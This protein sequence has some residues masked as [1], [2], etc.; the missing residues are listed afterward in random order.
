MTAVTL[1]RVVKAYPGGVRA[2]DGLNLEVREGERLVLYGPSGSG[3]TTALRLIA[4]L[5]RPTAGRVLLGDREVTS[6]PPHRRDV[7]LLFQTPAL[8]PHLT[9]RENLVFARRLDYNVVRRWWGRL[10]PADRT[11]A[12]ETARRLGLA[13]LLDRRPAE[14]SGGERQRVA[15]GRALLRR[16]AVFLLDEPL[17]HLD[18]PAR[19]ELR[20][21]LI[22]TLREA[23]AAS[24]WV[25]HDQAEAIAV[26]GRV[27]LL[28]AG[29]LEQVGPPRDLYKSPATLPAARMLGTPPVNELAGQLEADSAE[30]WLA[31]AAGRL[32]VGARRDDWPAARE[33]VL[34]VRPEDVR[35]GAGG[36]GLA[37]EVR[38]VE[39]GG[40]ITCVVVRTVAGTWRCLL[41][42]DARVREGE[43]VTLVWESGQA[44]LFDAASGVRLATG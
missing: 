12:E 9:V 19:L 21:V 17:A 32:P 37:G 16:P 20:E 40:H 28:R 33:A 5:D 15:L 31:T 24:V 38:A 23:G 26:G 13:A 34:A 35:M 39:F 4:G 41:P 1:E 11:L 18:P 8:F 10:R 30:A 36:H 3:K 42:R 27:G 7:A 2:L 44:M 25:T 29:R 43:R 22:A 14:L 6:L